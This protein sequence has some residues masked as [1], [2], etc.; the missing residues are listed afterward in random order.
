M[1]RLFD[2][3]AHRWAVMGLWFVASVFGIMM[4]IA[5]GILL[6]AISSEL[7]LTPRQQG[8]FGSSAFV[9]NLFL[10]LPLSWWMSRYRPKMLTTVTLALGAIFLFVLKD[11]YC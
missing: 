2:V 11:L 5:V 9:G 3:F 8:F 7:D 1:A 4:A 10:A 6:P